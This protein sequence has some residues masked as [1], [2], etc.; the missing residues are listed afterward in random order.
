[1]D[2]I[3]EPKPEKPPI[4]P[5]R[6]RIPFFA[7]LVVASLAALAAFVWFVVLPGVQAQV[8]TPAPVVAPVSKP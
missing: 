8:Q 6:W 4:I 7:G 1:M 2:R 5:A 3:Q